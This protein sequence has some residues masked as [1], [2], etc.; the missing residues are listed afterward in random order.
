M[1]VGTTVK[2]VFRFSF[3][4]RRNVRKG[5]QVEQSTP[6]EVTVHCDGAAEFDSRDFD[7]QMAVK[8]ATLD[9]HPH[10]TASSS[11]SSSCSSK[12]RL[13]RIVSW[14]N[15]MG[16]RTRWTTEQERE[17]AIAESQ[18][19]RCQKAWSSEQELWLGH[20]KA[21]TEEKEAHEE[22]LNHRAKQQDDEQQHF[23]KAWSRRKSSDEQP[24][25][26]P[27]HSPTR[28]NSRMRRRLSRR[29]SSFGPDDL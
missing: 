25:Q 28:A 9:L 1:R 18:L 12:T 20:I 13:V 21:L 17:L 19:A 22:F 11:S 2:Y 8:E 26:Q 24:Y 6:I 5:K 16:D 3:L 4:A 14:A 15:I 29:G 27:H 10:D 7:A 23:R